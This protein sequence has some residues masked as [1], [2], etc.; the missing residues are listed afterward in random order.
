M[1][2]SEL[3]IFNTFKEPIYVL[4]KKMRIIYFNEST[5]IF[6]RNNFNLEILPG[7]DISKFAFDFFKDVHFFYEEVSS[8]GKLINKEVT[9][10][11]NGL[12]YRI[13]IT[14][15]QLRGEKSFFTKIETDKGIN[16]S[17][18][19]ILNDLLLKYH[20]SKSKTGVIIFDERGSIIYYNK[21]FLEIMNLQKYEDY[22]AG[23][24]FRKIDVISLMSD[25]IVGAEDFFRFTKKSGKHG[26]KEKDIVFKNNKS[27]KLLIDPI[28][29][30]INKKVAYAFVLD[31]NPVNEV[32]FH[33]IFKKG[34]LSV[35]Q[36]AEYGVMIFDRHSEIHFVNN[37]LCKIL[38]YEP[39][40]LALQN[41]ETFFGYDENGDSIVRDIYKPENLLHSR[42]VFLEGK[43]KERYQ[44][45]VNFRKFQ[46]I[47]I[48]A[49]LI[50]QGEVFGEVRK[51]VK[52]RNIFYKLAVKLR[53]FNH[54]EVSL[55][56]LNRLGLLI[57]NLNSI[58]YP[59][60]GMVEADKGEILFP[61]ALDKIITLLKEYNFK[62]Q[63]LLNEIL[64][65][66]RLVEPELKSLNLF[67]KINTL[68]KNL[69][70]CI[71]TNSKIF[72]AILNEK[73]IVMVSDIISNNQDTILETVNK[74]KYIVKT[75]R[76]LLYQNFRTD[77]EPILMKIADNY[78]HK[79][80]DIP[81]EINA[82]KV[83]EVLIDK[84]E[85]KDML[86]ILF[87]NAY[88]AMNRSDSEERKIEIKI[89][90]SNNKCTLQFQNIGSTLDEKVRERLFEIGAS[91]NSDER[92]FGL[93]YIR[94]CITKFGGDIFYDEGF[95]DGVR[96]NLEFKQI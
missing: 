51:E 84:D 7:E 93:Y 92:G 59:S 44:F 54:N 65:L 2:S 15:I 8:K 34:D 75:V 58:M 57:K 28:L 4:D 79:Y 56:N 18:N 31:E 6:L 33:P 24:A 60:L 78:R 71:N 11:S 76:S 95:K 61:Q 40:E 96:F 32:N 86:E 90:P 17:E 3:K 30:N 72:S 64:L 36:S 41:A 26:C 47:F 21:K 20:Y 81:I 70:E 63:P 74:I 52:E 67:T 91:S 14:P 77:I 89:L 16:D 85:L 37:Y 48:Y 82:E 22:F 38:K 62:T 88:Q 45:K 87:N 49:A 13:Y 19:S 94:D 39:E 12:N 55:T 69:E 1:E 25:S 23:R 83:S 9:S 43:N 46:N 10:L 50:L 35:F 66:L 5:E 68:S 27:Y 29:N 73:E 80:T 42:N 53:N